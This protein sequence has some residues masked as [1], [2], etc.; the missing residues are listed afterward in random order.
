MIIIQPILHYTPYDR[1][2]TANVPSSGTSFGNKFRFENQFEL[3]E[4]TVLNATSSIDL[5]YRQ[6]ATKKSFDK[7]PVDTNKLGLFFSP[8]KEIDLDILKSVG[9]L[10]IDDYIGDPADNYNEEYSGLKTYRE[11][12]FQRY[13]LNFNEYVQL[14]RY[15]DK[16]LFDQLIT[17]VPA[18]AKVASG[19][20]LQPHILE[21]SKTKWNRPS[22]EENYH[23]ATISNTVNNQLSSSISNIDAL[24]SASEDI[25]PIVEY[26][27]IEGHISES[28]DSK[29]TVEIKNYDGTYQSEDDI[30]LSGTI[31]RNQSST[32][33]QFEFLVNAQITGSTLA[34]YFQT[35]GYEQIGMDF[36][37]LSRLGFGLYGKDSYSIRTRFDGRGNLIKDKV[38]VFKIKESYQEDVIININTNDSSMGT[39]VSEITKYKDKV[40]ILSQSGSAPTVGGNVT[41]VTPLDGFFSTHYVNVGDLTSGM[42]NSFFNGSKQ[43][44]ATTLDGGSPVQTFT[45]NPNTLRVSDS[46]RGSGEPILEV[47]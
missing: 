36:D 6:R 14:V 35:D 13:N 37:G 12:Y 19:L 38:R 43:T 4:D 33:G 15:F 47:D 31:T 11:Y 27:N 41:E 39:Q 5:S 9:P 17:L 44:S 18:R 21:R 46:G 32:G 42:E 22:G 34:S 3:G 23:E 1:T 30:S 24:V 40:V 26:N 2:V 25:N 20:L 45:T 8:T 28:D 10:N 29:V 7:A 16:T